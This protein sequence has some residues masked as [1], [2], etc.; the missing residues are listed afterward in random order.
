M[1]ALGHAMQVLVMVIMVMM[2]IEDYDD[3]VLNVN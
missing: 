1:C 2:L 3:V